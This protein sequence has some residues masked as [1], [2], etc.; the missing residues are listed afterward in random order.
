MVSKPSA[1]IIA[2]VA[3]HI[4]S[5]TAAHRECFQIDRCRQTEDLRTAELAHLIGILVGV[6]R[7][8]SLVRAV[9]A[10]LEEGR[11]ESWYEKKLRMKY[12]G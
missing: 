10:V 2:C 11:P 5:P 3:R 9:L 8:A 12:G 4:A 7:A 6:E 1:D